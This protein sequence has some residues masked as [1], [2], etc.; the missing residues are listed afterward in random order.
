MDKNDI[1]EIQCGGKILLIKCSTDT[2]YHYIPI[3]EITGFTVFERII[4]TPAY[5]MSNKDIPMPDKYTY[6]IKIC[7]RNYGS[8]Q[9]TDY[10]INEFKRLME[11]KEF[12]ESL[13]KKI[14]SDNN[15]IIR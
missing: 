13:L 10:V 2:Q 7:V 4:K 3:T 11:A 9:H 6:H 5:L 8:P 15:E 1:I 12:L 14:Y